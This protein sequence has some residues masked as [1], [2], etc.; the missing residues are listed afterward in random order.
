MGKN[1][2]YMKLFIAPPDGAKLS[3]LLTSESAL[4]YEVGRIGSDSPP[5]WLCSVRLDATWSE[6]HKSFHTTRDNKKRLY[7]KVNM[8]CWTVLAFRINFGNI[9]FLFGNIIVR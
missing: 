3:D 8:I 9:G 5:L 7:E 4:D 6:S 2:K 1:S